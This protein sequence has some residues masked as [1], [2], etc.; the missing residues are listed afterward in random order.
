MKKILFLQLLLLSIVITADAQTKDTLSKSPFNFHF[1]LTAINQSHPAF[2][3]PYSGTNSL[4]PAAE[5]ALSLTTTL[6]A[7]ARLWKGASVYFNPEISGGRGFSSAVGVAGF[8][9]GETFR[10]GS[11]APALYLARLFYRQYIALGTAVDTVADDINQVSELVPRKRIT[12]TAGK[13]AIAD[14]FDNNSYSHDPRTQFMNWSL[15]SA[16]AWD[17]PANT[18]GYTEGLVIEY[19]TPGWV[20]RLGTVLVPTYANGPTLDAHYSKAQGDVIEIQKNLTLGKHK[21]TIRLLGFRNVSK[22][23]N[24]RDVIKGYTNHTDSLD[25]ING[26]KYGGVK[27]GFGIN[28]EQE[29]TTDLGLFFR[30]SWNDGQTATW[31]FTEID[32]SGS[33]GL[34]LAGNRWHRPDDTFG[35]AAVINGISK[36]HRDYLATGGDGFIIGDGRL[37]NYKTENIAEAYY[38]AR[39][40]NYLHLS[41]GYQFIANPAYNGDRGPVNVFSVRVHIAI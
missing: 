15:M 29:L 4:Q 17:Y 33:V 13:F 14:M 35:I 24:Y 12:I 38:S 26:H 2:H 9:N 18:R 28:G 11:A 20:V 1:Q 31:A 36:A 5:E 40:N 30:T 8:P 32:H 16:G 7:G 21:G 34:N 19:A 22:A 39:I 41:A 25:V 3:A 23:P 37:S 6:F 27:Y 10:I